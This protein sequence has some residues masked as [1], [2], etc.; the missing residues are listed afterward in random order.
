MPIPAAFMKK[1]RKAAEGSAA[2][3]AG[4]SP[5]ME[6]AEGPDDN[7]MKGKKPC[8][9]CAKKGKKK[10]SCGCDK[11]GKMDAALTPMEYL[12]ACELGIQNRSRAYVRGV[13]GVREDKKCG[14]SGIAEGKKCNKGVVGSVQSALGDEKVQTGLKVA[15]VAGGIAAGTVGAMKYRGLQKNALSNLRVAKT[16][17][18]SSRTANPRPTNSAGGIPDPWKNEVTNAQASAARSVNNQQTRSMLSQGGAPLSKARARK[19]TKAG[20]A[21]VQAAAGPTVGAVKAQAQSSLNQA[22]RMARRTQIKAIRQKRN[23]FGGS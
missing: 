3:E 18:S 15:A 6:K 9:A 23:L 14:A 17:R 21:K 11:G 5:D 19:A 12:D 22:Q 8:K 1:G 20:V 16:M 13:L 7:E 2:E 10:G 4:E